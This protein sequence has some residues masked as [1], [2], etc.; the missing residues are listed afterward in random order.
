METDFTV[1][2]EY[3]D[4]EREASPLDTVVLW[5]GKLGITVAVI[6]LH[7]STS[8]ILVVHLLRQIL[9]VLLQGTVRPEQTW[10]QRAFFRNHHMKLQTVVIGTL[11]PISTLRV[12][13]SFPSPM[14]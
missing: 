8:A 12:T 10:N 11:S 7:L 4:G 14:N 6:F 13:Q 5:L 1:M 9:C 2:L 3:G